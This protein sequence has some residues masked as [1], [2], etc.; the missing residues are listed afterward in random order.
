MKKMAS[1][2]LQDRGQGEDGADDLGL[3]EAVIEKDFS[4]CF[5]C[6]ASSLRLCVSALRFRV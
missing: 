1:S 4:A 5:A 2:S 3:G 6:S